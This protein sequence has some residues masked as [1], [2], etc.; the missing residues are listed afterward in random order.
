MILSLNLRAR[1]FALW[2]ALQI[3]FSDRKNIL[4]LFIERS[5]SKMWHKFLILLTMP[6]VGV[7]CSKK[8]N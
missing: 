7:K 3:L 8:S 4:K 1:D 2:Q 5:S 6:H